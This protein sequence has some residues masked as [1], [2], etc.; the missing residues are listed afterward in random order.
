M[1]SSLLSRTTPRA[2][3]PCATLFRGS[4]FRYDGAIRTS[5][6]LSRVNKS[7]L[8]RR[9]VP[10][11]NSMVPSQPNLITGRLQS[12]SSI[13]SKPTQIIRENGRNISLGLTSLVLVAQYFGSTDD[14]F[15]FRFIVDK[16]PDD[17]ASFY[18]SDSFMELY[19][20]FPFVQELMMRGGE[21]DDEGVVHTQGF[22]GELLVSMVFSD[23]TNEET[24][25]TSWFNKR[26]RFKDVFLGYKMWD[27]IVNFGFHRLPDGRLQVYHKGE[28]FHGY[29]PVVSLV[30]RMVFSFHARYV[31][32]ATEFH[33]TH[34]AF[35]ENEDEEEMEERARQ[36][37]PWHIVRDHIFRD[38]KAMIFGAE[39]KPIRIKNEDTEEDEDEEEEE[40]EVVVAPHSTLKRRATIMSDIAE[41]KAFH[42]SESN[43]MNKVI[44]DIGARENDTEKKMGVYRKATLA[45]LHRHAT[46]RVQRRNS[47]LKERQTQVIK[48]DI[49]Q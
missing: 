5:T 29:L 24:G 44:G 43:N 45:A 40:D 37:M 46:L 27:M 33:L 6:V 21:F 39:E 7:A 19:C 20:I 16:D 41:D 8:I 25:Q 49:A 38:I 17:L 4:S 9:K 13:L 35:T 18:G 2:V 31:A 22:P 15:D 12:S 26:E 36:N 34:Y 10:M 28:Y 14:Y 47:L 3:K 11:N 1:L 48:V 42:M 30:L 32:W 23:E